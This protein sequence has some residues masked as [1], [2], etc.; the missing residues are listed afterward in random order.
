MS[1]VKG[2]KLGDLKKNRCLMQGKNKSIKRSDMLSSV[3]PPE[4][5]ANNTHSLYI[6]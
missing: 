4:T 3:D 5:Q 1:F 6:P 2:G